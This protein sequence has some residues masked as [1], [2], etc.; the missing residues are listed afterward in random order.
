MLKFERDVDYLVAKPNHPQVHTVRLI[1][2]G[3]VEFDLDCWDLEV[4]FSLTGVL[5]FGTPEEVVAQAV[6]SEHLKERLKPIW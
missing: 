3:P 6:Q 4:N 2:C 5:F 1:P